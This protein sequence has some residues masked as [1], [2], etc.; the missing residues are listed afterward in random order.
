MR[1]A[2]ILLRGEGGL[3]LR[4]RLPADVRGLRR[5]A[6]HVLVVHAC[7]VRARAIL[8][9]FWLGVSSSS[10]AVVAEGDGGDGGGCSCGVRVF[11]DCVYAAATVGVDAV[12]VVVDLCFYI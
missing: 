7:W 2:H 8:C 4:R 3:A 9:A 5:R 12:L 11:A 1:V 6:S 10:F